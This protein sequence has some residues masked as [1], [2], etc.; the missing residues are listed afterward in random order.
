MTSPTG[1]ITFYDTQTEAKQA[2]DDLNVDFSELT[3]VKVLSLN[4]DGTIKIEDLA[5][6]IQ[7]INSSV[8]KGYEKLQTEE[9]KLAKDKETLDRELEQLAPT[10]GSVQSISPVPGEFIGTDNKAKDVDIVFLATTSPSEDTAGNETNNL[11]HI[12]RARTFLNNFKFFKNRNKIKTIIVT[13]SNVKQLGLEGLI[14]VSYN[15]NITDELTEDETNVETGFMA[16]VFIIQTPQG[17]FFINEKGEKLNKIGESSDTILDNVVFQTMTSASLFTEGGYTKIRKGQEEQADI[18]LEAY[19]IFRQE[20]SGQTGY[21]PY[22]FNISRGIPNQNVVNGVYEDNHIGDILGPNA[23]EIIT[24]QNGLIEVVTTGQ[25][26]NNGE[27]LSF[28]I[29][30]TLILSLI[31]I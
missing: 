30:T 23:E 19:K 2:V 18:A 7:N 11:P 28:P 21:T 27:L 15:K 12:K 5:G 10:G 16:Q 9:E 26:G 1:E 25:V 8:L 3:T 29:G 6:N 31:H 22:P 4:E 24:K 14:Q 13:P 20:L 17:N